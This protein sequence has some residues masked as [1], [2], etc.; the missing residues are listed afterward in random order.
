ME[1]AIIA[2]IKDS[3]M[4]LNKEPVKINPYDIE[5]KSKDLSDIKTLYYSSQNVAVLMTGIA[6]SVNPPP[7]LYFSALEEV[8]NQIKERASKGDTSIVIKLAQHWGC[9]CINKNCPAQSGIQ[10]VKSISIL[11]SCAREDQDTGKT[12]VFFFPN[13]IKHN[14]LWS[15]ILFGLKRLGFY[16]KNIELALANDEAMINWK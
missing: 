11:S 1:N 8:L 6:H 9:H 3:L 12:C 14:E 16:V 5:S 7:S 4:S 10:K 13:Y 15:F 2:S